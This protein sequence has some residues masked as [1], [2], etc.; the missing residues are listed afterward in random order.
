MDL[1][2]N[3]LAKAGVNLAVKEL[4]TRVISKWGPHNLSGRK[5]VRA[6]D[7][8][9]T[10]IN[11]LQKHVSRVVRL[12]TIHS[13]DYDVFLHRIYHPLKICLTGS[14][15]ESM[16]VGDDFII[17]DQHI[18]N[19]IG[20]AGQGKSTILRK[21]FLETLK[22]GD[23]VP[24]FIELR[25]VEEIGIFI[26]LKEALNSLG[27][28][29][30]DKDISELLSSN[31]IVLMLDGFD[32]ISL[33]YR[34]KILHEVTQLSIKHAV[35]IIT[36][37]RPGT[38]ICHEPL[39]I[40]YK[41]RDLNEQDILA[42]IEKLNSNESGIDQAQLPKIKAVIRD[43]DNLVAVM[44]TP[45]LVTL[46]HVCY[47]YMD[48]IPKN[49]VE[50][51]SSLFMTLYLRHDKIKN[52]EREKSAALA[53]NE[54]YECFCALC[55]H[56]FYENS[57]DFN[58]TDFLKY[59]EKALIIKNKSESCKPEDLAADFLNI[60]CMIQKDGYDRYVFIHKSIQEYHAAEFIKSISSD[61]KVK[62][63]KVMVDDN[64]S[65]SYRYSNVVSFLMEI[66]EINTAK[67]FTINLCEHFNID[68]WSELPAQALR[69]L[70]LDIFSQAMISVNYD[71]DDIQSIHF[72]C[73]TSKFN[74]LSLYYDKNMYISP[75]HEKVHYFLLH[76]VILLPDFIILNKEFIKPR[77]K[78]EV[79]YFARICKVED[80]IIN[81]FKETI[82][83]IYNKVYMENIDKVKN[84]SLSIKEFFDL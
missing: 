27:V 59:T 83:E 7:S 17:S 35:Q 77:E 16:V 66:D 73:G 42:I 71:N 43:N 60:T 45:I 38:S 26:G 39:I 68:K 9:Q 82:D 5:I 64:I 25:K 14:R 32:E 12:R 67:H 13:A 52:F 76:S 61:L 34:G 15:S 22:S 18:N 57:H 3:E 2:F 70:Y 40:N 28:K 69:D 48:I 58:H 30:E 33:R 23:K 80:E 51:Y 46:F 6:L 11:Y 79:S 21:L 36:T 4:F 10:F 19:I 65:N 63:Y 78:Y 37:S 56:T 31:R 47:P 62:F 29:S 44:R 55:F 50:F 75:L 72:E 41:V 8:E 49:T 74:W 1:I 84:E 20:T 53:H 81:T 24:F 54:A